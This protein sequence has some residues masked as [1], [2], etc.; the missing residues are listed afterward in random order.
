MI[1][2]VLV[3]RKSIE[4]KLVDIVFDENIVSVVFERVLQNLQ[5]SVS[6]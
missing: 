3:S 1:L 2:C 4:D 6:P 5:Y